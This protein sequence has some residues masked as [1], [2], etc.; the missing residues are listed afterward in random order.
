MK[1]KIIIDDKMQKDYYYLTEE[2]GENLH[3]EFKPEL[4]PKELL[5]LGT[6]GGKYMTDCLSEFP[7]NWFKDAKLSSGKKDI[8]LNYYRVDA[9]LPLKKWQE[10]GMII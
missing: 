6:F 1:K 10:K 3:S 9:S 5:A 8:D 4:S 7:E 2:E